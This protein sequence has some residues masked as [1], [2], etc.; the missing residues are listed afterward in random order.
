[1]SMDS[2]RQDRKL[3]FGRFVT[4]A[5]IDCT[6]TQYCEDFSRSLRLRLVSVKYEEP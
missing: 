2:L 5:L 4:I 1:M 6:G 3:S